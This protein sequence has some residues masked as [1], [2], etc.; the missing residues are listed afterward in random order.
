MRRAYGNIG[1]VPW[2]AHF[3]VALFRSLTCTVAFEVQ[4]W[5]Q[6]QLVE[7]G[8]GPAIALSENFYI[9]AHGSDVLDQ[10]VKRYRSL[11]HR[12]R[13]L[14]IQSSSEPGW[15]LCSYE[16]GSLEIVV[17]DTGAKLEHGVDESYTIYVKGCDAVRTAPPTALLSANT[18]WGALH[19]LE[20]FSQLVRRR[21][22]ANSKRFIPHNV[23]INDAPN[24]PHR[25]I[26]LD[27]SRN[28]YP[29]DAILRTLQAMA[30]NK[31]NV[32]HWHITDSHSFPL[33]LS[34]EPELANLGAYGE[35]ERYSSSD[36]RKIIEFARLRGVRVIPEI[37][38]PGHTG[39]WAEAYPDIVACHDQFWL[40]PPGLWS[41]RF[42]AEPGGVGQLNPLRSQTY[43]V[44]KNV[45]DEVADMFS[46]NFFHGG[47]DE[48]NQGCWNN[49]TDI[50]D[51]VK[52]GGTLNELLT[53]FITKA[54]SY[55]TA[56]KK[57]AIY[58]ED[59]ILSGSINVS[60]L[61]LPPKTTILQTW[62]RGPANTKLL[63]SAGYRTIVSSSDFFYLD[64]GRGGWVGNDSRYDQQV[65]NDPL[66]RVNYGGDGGSWCAPFKTWARVYDYDITFNLTSKEA[67]LVLGGEVALWSEQADETVLDSLL[68]PRSSALAESLWSGNRGPNG[69]KRYAEALNRLNDWRYRLLARGINAE[70]LQPYW[71]L[72]HP[73]QCNVNA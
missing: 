28:F 53:K 42:G 30:Y 19:G 72:K 36:V 67:K 26:I 1:L 70:P 40:P 57:T 48:V 21:N 18:V 62:N 60:T 73:G 29:V 71:C 17:G 5:P 66:N 49:S 47:G 44:V 23:L 20:T 15:S 59:V 46:D 11:L 34:K 8:N 50:R 27:T 43:K 54:H 45:V 63:T 13:W 14:P 3:V 4:L 38:M 10:A 58:W 7:W 12:E 39:S 51:Y 61:V 6:P 41:E 31:L 25:G 32:F 33:E 2:L 69:M 52:G 24:F 9:N 37:D 16:L 55:I 65:D 68:W 56:K 22:S 35:K 64:C